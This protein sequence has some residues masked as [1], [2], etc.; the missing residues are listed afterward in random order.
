MVQRQKYHNKYSHI[1]ITQVMK[2]NSNNENSN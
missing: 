2:I 1:H